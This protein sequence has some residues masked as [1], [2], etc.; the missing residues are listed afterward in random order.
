MY[1]CGNQ[2]TTTMGKT[3][4]STLALIKQQI[5]V[6]LELCDC[7]TGV[8]TR[9]KKRYF[10]AILKDRVAESKDFDALKRIENKIGLQIEPNGVRRIAIYF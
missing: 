8:K 6:T 9:N 4:N 7:F 5:G 1:I 10:N 3:I 2:T